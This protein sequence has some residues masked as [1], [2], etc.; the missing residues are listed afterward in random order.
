LSQTQLGRVALAEPQDF[1][2][3][4]THVHHG[5]GLERAGAG[6]YHGAYLVLKAFANFFGVIQRP[7]VAGQDEGGGQQWG[8]V[9]GQE[10]LQ[11]R[12]IGHPQAN[13]FALW[14]ADPARH[15]FGGF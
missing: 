11:H 4:A 12:V 6:V 5:G 2:L 1:G 14:V 7:I 9:Q 13:G 3:I 10:F 8:A 15:F